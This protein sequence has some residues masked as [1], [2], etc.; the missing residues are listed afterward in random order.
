LLTDLPQLSP[1]IR[2]GQLLA[3]L[4]FLIEDPTDQ[5]VWDVERARLL[6]VI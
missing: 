6:E 4:G 3:N 2:F 1:D 5:S